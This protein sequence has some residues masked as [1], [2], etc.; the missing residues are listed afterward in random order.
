MSRFSINRLFSKL[1]IIF[2]LTQVV[3][4]CLVLSVAAIYIDSIQERYT[5]ATPIQRIKQLVGE[6]ESEMA[7]GGVVA[8]LEWLRRID[9]EEL[10]PLLM[11]DENNR[12]ILGRT[13]APRTMDY[14][15]NHDLFV[16]V[17][18]SPRPFIDIVPSVR[19]RFFYDYQ[20]AS[21]QR[22]L[23]RPKV[24]V[25]PL[26]LASL[27]AAL[28]AWFLANYLSRPIALLRNAMLM[29]SQGHLHE[30]VAVKLGKRQDELVDL[31]HSLDHMVRQWINMLNSQKNLLRDVSHDLRSPLTRAQIALSLIRQTEDTSGIDQER[32]LSRVEDELIRLDQLIGRILLFTKLESGVQKLDFRPFNWHTMLSALM[33][34]IRYEAEQ[35][36]LKILYHQNVS[37]EALQALS[38]YE[39][40]EWLWRRAIENVLRNAIRYTPI[41][42]V[43][44]LRLMAEEGATFPSINYKLTIEDEGCGV[45]EYLLPRLFEPFF[46]VE[47]NTAVQDLSGGA[48]LSGH[49]GL[50]LAITQRA[51]RLHHGDVRAYNR[52]AESQSKSIN[53][54]VVEL[55]WNLS[56]P[57][58]IN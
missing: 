24:L 56:A 30:S 46:R 33:E 18:E 15:K 14:I 2:W 27:V 48:S 5:Y 49:D 25:V 10:V 39:G 44:H 23:S 28:V 22:F 16:S 8:L 52:Y 26:L 34:D 45:A 11:V 32:H 40:D 9:N 58:F 41:A 4:L 53:G 20:S 35:K 57:S 19:Y 17:G 37:A 47:A 13:I 6:A 42:S 12:D 36:K 55:A 54:L 43:I 50:G 21:M 7:S 29:F 31:A 38:H 51:I 3:F 1:L